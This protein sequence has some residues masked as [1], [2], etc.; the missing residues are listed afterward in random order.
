MVILQKASKA[1]RQKVNE[2]ET[3]IQKVVNTKYGVRQLI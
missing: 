3:Q 1:F 2:Q